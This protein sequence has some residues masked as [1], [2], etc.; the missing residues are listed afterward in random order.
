MIVP[1]PELIL[2]ATAERLCVSGGI[3]MPGFFVWSMLPLLQS[4]RLD[5]GTVLMWLVPLSW[6]QLAFEVRLIFSTF[7]PSIF[8][9]FILNTLESL[10]LGSALVSWPLIKMLITLMIWREWIASSYKVIVSYNNARDIFLYL[11][12]FSLYYGIKIKSEILSQIFPLNG[13]AIHIS[14][15]I[16]QICMIYTYIK[17][18]ILQWEETWKRNQACPLLFLYI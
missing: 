13:N 5:E 17:L 12:S 10:I 11:C 1:I 3:A 16:Y 15:D 6:R 14:S 9:P 2:E 4:L 8:D 7:S 18:Y